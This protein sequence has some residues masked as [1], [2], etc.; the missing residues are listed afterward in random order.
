MSNYRDV[1]DKKNDDA[2]KA[3]KKQ[4]KEAVEIEN[5]RLQKEEEA[6]KQAEDDE[7]DSCIWLA[8]NDYFH[9]I[10]S[11]SISVTFLFYFI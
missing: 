5:E 1:E 9:R 11:L 7:I 3:L 10:P 6:M 2:A 8:Y 4:Q